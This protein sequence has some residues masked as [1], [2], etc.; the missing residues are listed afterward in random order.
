LT[1]TSISIYIFSETWGTS[2]SDHE[3]YFFRDMAPFILVATVRINT[4][5]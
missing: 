4:I 2:G 1:N 5:L 3:D